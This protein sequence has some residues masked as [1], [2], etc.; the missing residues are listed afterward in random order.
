MMV[1]VRL[2]K[3]LMEKLE[4]IAKREKLTKSEVIKKALDEY[5]N[6][7]AKTRRPYSLGKDLFGKYGSGRGNLSV[8][9]KKKVRD[10]QKYSDVPMDLADATL[11]VISEK[12][13]IKE[14]VTI[15]SDFY[16]YRNIRNEWLVNIFKV[17]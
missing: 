10:N 4:L 14:I 8:K 6:K 1:S 12:E 15:D 11:I 9:Y 3:Y 13:N 16:I 7:Y 17:Y 5:F 2:P